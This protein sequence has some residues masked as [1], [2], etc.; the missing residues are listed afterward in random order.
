MPFL[1]LKRGAT[2]A[3][4]AAE[5]LPLVNTYAKLDPHNFPQ[6]S[7]VK[8]KTLNEELMRG[9][10]SPLLML[11]AAVLLPLLIGCANVSILML[12]PGNFPSV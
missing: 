6:K 4:F 9:F 3:A 10:K 11:F 1:K 2:F 5:L 12:A 7:K 8:I